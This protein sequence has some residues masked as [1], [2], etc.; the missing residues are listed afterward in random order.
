MYT[1]D[2]AVLERWMLAGDELLSL[3]DGG[4]L[5]TGDA[6]I[7]QRVEDTFAVDELLSLP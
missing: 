1:C 4:A 2:A 7:L 3:D 6:A 5:R